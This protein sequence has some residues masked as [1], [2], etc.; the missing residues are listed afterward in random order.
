MTSKI[1]EGTG[2]AVKKQGGTRRHRKPSPT[3]G[4]FSME[5][6]ARFKGQKEQA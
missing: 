3:K 6:R 2:Y 4:W 5:Q 1:K